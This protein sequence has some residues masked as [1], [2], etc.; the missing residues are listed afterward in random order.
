MHSWGDVG[1][2]WSGINDA[3]WYIAKNLR[4]Y[5]RI[6]VRDWKEKFGT[7][8][9]YCSIGFDCFHSLVWPG[10]V[11]IHKWW[12]YKLDLWLS[13]KL[14]LLYPIN[15]IVIPY[16]KWVYGQVYKRAVQK[17]PHLRDEIVSM[18]D[19]GEILEGRVPGYKH[20]DYWTKL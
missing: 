5:G 18:A 16:Q 17:W 13:Y 20:D 1:V 9:V 4:R 3:A 15:Y 6:G 19:F 14:R 2:D 10:H 11:W 7:V 8:R 12:P